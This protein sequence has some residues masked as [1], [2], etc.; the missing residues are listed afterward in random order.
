MAE[1]SFRDALG[2]LQ[3]V[4]TVSKDKKVDVAEVEQ[5]TGAPTGEILRA[6]VRALNMG[7]VDSALGAIQKAMAAN[8]DARTLLKLLLERVRLVILARNAP[9]VA[10]MHKHE[11]TE[12]DYG[13]LE[14]MGKEKESKI[15]SHLLKALLAAHEEMAY[16]ALPH[17]PIELA[18]LDT[19]KSE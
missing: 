16:A 5:V 19:L 3:K 10:A 8:M 13:E 7:D 9:Q 6:V 11:F 1:G 14:Q 18:I 4:L 12:A 15:N 2:I 17:L